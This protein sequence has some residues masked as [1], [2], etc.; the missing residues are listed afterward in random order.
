MFSKLAKNLWLIFVIVTTL[1]VIPIFVHAQPIYPFIDSVNAKP[2]GYITSVLETDTGLFVGSENGLYR[3]QGSNR[4][5]IEKF[6]QYIDNGF[7]SDIAQF[8]DEQVLISVFGSGLYILNPR[9]LSAT[10]YEISEVPLSQIWKVDVS[11][12]LVAVSTVN[13]IYVLNFETGEILLDLNKIGVEPYAE[14][15]NI[16]FTSDALWFSD[17]EN[18]MFSIDLDTYEVKKYE[19]RVRGL[20]YNEITSFYVEDSELF[21]GTDVGLITQNF[22]TGQLSLYS[23]R[24]KGFGVEDSTQ[25]PVYYVGRGLDG[26]IWVGAEK[27]YVLNESTGYFELPWFVEQNL[28]VD[29]IEIVTHLVFSHTGYMFLVDTQ[30]GL[31][32]I[33]NFSRNTTVLNYNNEPF[34]QHITSR[35]KYGQGFLVASEGRVYQVSSRGKIVN[36]ADIGEP[37]NYYLSTLENENVYIIK[38]SGELYTLNPENFSVTELNQIELV[39]G[40]SVSGVAALSGNRWI[41]RLESSQRSGIYLYDNNELKEL[42]SGDVASFVPLGDEFIFTK[43][44][45]GI[46]IYSQE[47]VRKIGNGIDFSLSELNSVELSL[48]GQNVW[49]GASSGVYS[50]F[51][52]NDEVLRLDNS[53]PGIVNSIIEVKE[54]LLITTSKGL[55]FYNFGRKSYHLIDESYGVIDRNFEYNSM[56]KNGDGILILGDKNTYVIKM[57]YLKGLVSSVYEH[58]I[59]VTNVRFFDNKSRM[60]KTIE[61]DMQKT[62]PFEIERDHSWVEVEL[63]INKP[64]YSELF[65]V[66]YRLLNYSDE[67]VSQA[68]SIRSIEFPSLSPGHYRLEV[69]VALDGSDQLFDASHIDIVVPIPFYLSIYAYMVYFLALLFLVYSFLSGYFLTWIKALFSLRLRNARNLNL[70]LQRKNDLAATL[71]RSNKIIE[72]F[73]EEIKSRVYEIKVI[74]ETKSDKNEWSKNKHIFEE[75][76]HELIELVEI[77]Q[78]LNENLLDKDLPN[79][80]V[81]FKRDAKIQLEMINSLVSECN[82]VLQYTVKGDGY[83]L[84]PDGLLDDL[85]KSPLSALKYFFPD[86]ELLKLDVRAEKSKIVFKLLLH[87]SRINP[88]KYKR[89][90]FLRFLNNEEEEVFGLGVLK[91]LVNSHFGQFCL[92]V[93]AGKLSI[94]Y[95]IPAQS[96]EIHIDDNEELQST[97][98][99]DGVD[100]EVILVVLPSQFIRSHIFELL[101]GSY[102]ILTARNG[103][104]CMDILATH[105]P[106]LILLDNYL[107]D[108][109]GVSLVRKIRSTSGYEYVPTVILSANNDEKWMQTA[110]AAKVTSIIQKPVS[111][112]VLISRLKHLVDVNENAKILKASENK[113]KDDEVIQSYLKIPKFNNEK[114]LN[115]YLKFIAVLEKNYKNEGF[116]RVQAADQMLISVRQ[117]NRRLSELFEYNFTEFLSR[118][119]IDK[120]IKALDKSGAIMDLSLDVG[121]GTPTYFSTTFKRV[122]GMPP[123]KFQDAFFGTRKAKNKA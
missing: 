87:S 84:L 50:Y 96:E 70:I 61:F 116:N 38:R 114:D 108:I 120:A 83:Y 76:T 103:T 42:V 37:D 47:Q 105:K 56:L 10:S 113:L 25:L 55:F 54:G 67:W 52:E 30:R 111:D 48:S 23:H 15:L 122:T 100:E 5:A 102:G 17:R 93:E 22:L 12:H 112:K 82:G 72:K 26:N 34:L 45:N 80:I 62:S 40:E 27:L 63:N 75:R 88:Q 109:E 7:V 115:F 60:F 49:I 104:E 32:G 121:F 123:K 90:N 95:S 118:Y 43:H 81:N 28:V 4:E 31:L 85:M 117:L 11:E 106:D 57:E 66:E 91:T 41:I 2:M 74:S 24:P 19:P 89:K 8:D 44:G 16:Q 110:F 65:K 77:L 86:S 64:I 39:K 97:S 59:N 29:N 71:V 21:I 51:L 9:S 99:T 53:P 73:N 46:F 79:K 33:S 119:R 68:H 6:D 20:D 35:D 69:R 14:I 36:A 1:L 58:R 78:H 92:I 3:I 18:A 13:N 94:N 98:V 107:P 101:R